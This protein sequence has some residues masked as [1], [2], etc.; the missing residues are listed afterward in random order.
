MPSDTIVAEI[1]KKERLLS[2]SRGNPNKWFFAHEDSIPTE[3]QFHPRSYFAPHSPEIADNEEDLSDSN[4][5]DEKI[6]AMNENTGGNVGDIPSEVEIVEKLKNQEICLIF[7]P[8]H[9][10]KQM[11]KKKS[12]CAR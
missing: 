1:E 9:Q 8:E 6:H 12:I 3:S 4:S 2:K 10:D 5:F 7:R 11:F